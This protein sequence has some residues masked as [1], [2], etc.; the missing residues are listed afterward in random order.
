MAE[1]TLIVID[2]TRVALAVLLVVALFLCLYP[3]MRKQ[4]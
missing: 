4:E 2:W 3:W 1:M